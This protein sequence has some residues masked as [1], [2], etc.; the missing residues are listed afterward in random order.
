MPKIS[1]TP[2]LPRGGREQMPDDMELET[3]PY[4]MEDPG[5]PGGDLK[6]NM[7]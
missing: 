1:V 6:K 4:M 2:I 3:N 7:N 5:K